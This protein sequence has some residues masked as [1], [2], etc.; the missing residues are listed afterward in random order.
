MHEFAHHRRRCIDQRGNTVGK[1]G[2]DV[3]SGFDQQALEDGIK[4]RHM[5]RIEVLCAFR[6]Q[7]AELADSLPPSR[8]TDVPNE[9]IKVRKRR[10]GG[11]HGLLRA[12]QAVGGHVMGRQ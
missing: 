7:H 9:F 4:Q 11:E 2:A 6:K 10:L 5:L 8:G 3:A 1:I 12:L